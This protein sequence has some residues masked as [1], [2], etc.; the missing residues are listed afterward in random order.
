MRLL[1]LSAAL[2]NELAAWAKV[3]KIYEQRNV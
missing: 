3:I 1:R 2:W